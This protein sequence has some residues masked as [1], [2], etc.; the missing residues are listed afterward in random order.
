MA[1]VRISTNF[2]I[3]IEF[4]GS[5]FHKRMIAWAIDLVIQIFYILIS[6]RIVVW[7]AGQYKESDEK[8][9]NFWAVGLLVILPFFTYHLICEV[10]MNGQSIGKKLMKLK[11]IS[12]NGAK[13]S[14]S[15]YIIRW[16]IRTSD[17]SVLMIILYA[18]YFLMFGS[19]IFWAIG[20]AFA[21]LIT[22]VILVNSSKKNQRLGDMI[23][24][25]LLVKT[26]EQA[27]IDNTIFLN[28]GQNYT[29]S[30]PQVMQLS[31]R[32]INALKS[33]LDNSRKTHNYEL[34]EQASEK[35]KTHLKISSSISPFDFLEI[36]LK[37]YNYLST[38]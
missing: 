33:I 20:G 25:T 15:Q 28:V 4:E 19:N 34:A 30:F 10:L 5:P 1:T 21:L 22:D 31:D 24:H 12:E 9:Y 7:I 17:Y 32:D 38:Q 2:N 35:I 29:P 27:D 16:L 23:A 11:V 6:N 36:L 37:D 3:D 18:P 26:G 13:P 14:L 8:N